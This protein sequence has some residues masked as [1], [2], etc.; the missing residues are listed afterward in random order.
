MA[1]SDLIIQERFHSG[2]VYKSVVMMRGKLNLLVQYPR[3]SNVW[4][5]PPTPI[6]RGRRRGSCF[7]YVKEEIHA[8][9]TS[10]R[11]AITFSK[12]MQPA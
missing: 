12:A 1:V 5:F 8:L 9:R 4:L 11:G 6:T 10:F 3:V 2:A 7:E